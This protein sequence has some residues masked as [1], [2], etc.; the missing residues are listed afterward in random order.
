MENSENLGFM[1]RQNFKN[2]SKSVRIAAGMH[3]KS[4]KLLGLPIWPQKN[5][6]LFGLAN[7]ASKNAK[8]VRIGLQNGNF[9]RIASGRCSDGIL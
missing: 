4:Q 6:N 1:Y 8:F 2:F 7:Q 9:A 3:Q 5:P